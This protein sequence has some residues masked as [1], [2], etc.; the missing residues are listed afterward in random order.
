MGKKTAVA[1]TENTE[2]SGSTKGKKIILTNKEDGS[3]IARVDYIQ[4]RFAEG[5]KRGEI[6]KE[7]KDKFDHVVPYQIVFAATKPKKAANAEGASEQ[8][9][10]AAE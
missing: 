5:A 8:T 3:T 1:E 2:A 9:A 7:L 4:Q 6:V 10:E